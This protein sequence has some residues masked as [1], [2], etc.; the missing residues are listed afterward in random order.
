MHHLFCWINANAAGLTAI[1][2]FLY[3]LATILIF[4]EARKSADAATEAAKAAK[5]NATA[6]KQAASAADSSAI[7]AQQSVAL[8]RQQL[9][10]QENLGRSIVITTIDSAIRT[11]DHWRNLH[12]ENF[13]SAQIPPTDD[14]V[15]DTASSA[16]EH[17]R[18]ISLDVVS[19]L[20]SA[21][22]DLK[23]AKLEIELQRTSEISRRINT[24]R[25]AG[26]LNNAFDKFMRV[27]ALVG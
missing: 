27:R 4:N 6:A 11:I 10:E 3:L 12:L 20:S 1:F 16:V 13:S 5:D 14:F 7:A 25:L 26:H 17:S 22:D 18:R 8:V 24:N 19:Q 2:T 9:E 15:P 23:Q 21:F